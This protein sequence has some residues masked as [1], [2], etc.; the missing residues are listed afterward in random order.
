MKTF[1]FVP[2]DSKMDGYIDVAEVTPCTTDD[3]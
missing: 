1:G 3:F 2:F